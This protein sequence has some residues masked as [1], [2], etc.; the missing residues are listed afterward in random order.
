MTTDTPQA[1]LSD[2]ENELGYLSEVFACTS[3]YLTSFSESTATLASYAHCL[4]SDDRCTL[5]LSL[6]QT[7]GNLRKLAKILAKRDMD[8]MEISIQD[9]CKQAQKLKT[10]KKKNRHSTG[11][12][13]PTQSCSNQNGDEDLKEK[14]SEMDEAEY[15]KQFYEYCKEEQRL[16]LQPITD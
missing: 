11:A 3:D 13:L 9:V 1:P 14:D 6:G 10:T 7:M 15:L 5:Q 4:D 12:S 8:A 2:F 16:A